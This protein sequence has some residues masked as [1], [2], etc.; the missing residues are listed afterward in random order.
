M[1]PDDGHLVFDDLA[2]TLLPYTAVAPYVSGWS[3]I[4]TLPLVR[5]G[6][7]P[8]YYERRQELLD[9]IAR[10][11]EAQIRIADMGRL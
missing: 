11:R 5:V 7:S 1:P 4:G 6:P 2:D 9:V 10:A 8:G 3:G